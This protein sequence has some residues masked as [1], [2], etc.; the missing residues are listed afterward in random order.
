MTT[1]MFLWQVEIPSTPQPRGNTD[2][3]CG[4]GPYYKEQVEKREDWD[5]PDEDPPDKL[6][7]SEKHTGLIKKGAIFLKCVTVLVTTLVVLVG[8]VVSKGL[9]VLMFSQ[10]KPPENS[11][12]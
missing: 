2:Q 10:V 5:K 11:E 4:D 9:I 6:S 1:K 7:D 12:R 3:P 8:G